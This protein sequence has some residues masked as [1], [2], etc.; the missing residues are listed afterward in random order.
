MNIQRNI[1]I[2]GMAL[3]MIAG[4]AQNLSKSKARKSFENIRKAARGGFED[5]RKQAMADFIKF[6]RNPWREFE[7]TAPIPMPKE[8]PIP[9]VVMPKEDEDKPIE[10]KPI[11]IK[12]VIS[13]ISIVP[14]PKP[15]EPIK[16]V[17]VSNVKYVQFSFFGTNA[18]VRFDVSKKYILHG[19][20]SD[21]IANALQDMTSKDY[22]NLII[23]CLSLRNNLKLC[24]WAYLQMLKSISDKVSGEGTNEAT[25]LMAYLYLQSGYKMRLAT[26]G[27]KLYMLYA[28]E[29][30]IY[31]AVMY[32]VNGDLYYGVDKLP[33]K[34]RI[35]EASFPKEQSM[36]LYITSCQAFDKFY[37]ESRDIVSKSYPNIKIS[38][39]VNKNL[40]D[41]Y[42]T[43]P[44]SMVDNNFM[45]KWNM[46]AQTPLDDDIRMQ[47]YPQ[48]ESVIK[49]MNKPMAVGRLLNLLQTGLK[50]EYDN[51]VWGRDR[52]F[53]AEETLYY[54]YCDCEDRA[55]LLS[56][57]VKD[58]LG[59]DTILVYY[60]GHLAMAI[61][62][63]EDVNGD[64][65]LYQGKRFV[66]CDPT[67]IGAPI[68]RTMPGM[69]NSTA[70]VI[71]T[72]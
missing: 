29:H 37:S 25:L 15:I 32:K 28:S 61:A 69:D 30:Q 36:S 17:P 42:N 14:Q 59:L 18:M 57:L 60:P 72:E 27:T 23:D 53:F 13:P 70:T 12:G 44:A 7:E 20:E 43:Y 16:E 66:I 48:L 33:M 65:I 8:D 49:G 26:D 10:N 45:T 38:V 71:L 34:L 51:K 19:V 1:F 21:N 41:F 54:P 3:C 2:L 52:A 35:C 6:A 55:I 68:G 58:L 11:K 56:R 46:Y 4:H 40:I 50:Y 24:D 22:D 31:D 62:F 39:N 64:Y 67:Y 63:N 47:V 5:F 9:P